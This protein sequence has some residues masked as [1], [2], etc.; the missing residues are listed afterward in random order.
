MTCDNE[1]G[2]DDYRHLFFYKTCIL[3]NLGITGAKCEKN[4]K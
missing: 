1:T 2:R 3:V 4:N